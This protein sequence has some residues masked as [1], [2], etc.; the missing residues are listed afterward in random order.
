MA[1]RKIK[2]GDTGR[3]DFQGDVW[4]RDYKFVKSLGGG[5]WE[6]EILPVRPET[7]DEMLE[8]AATEEEKGYGGMF[9]NGDKL[10]A[11]EREWNE[12]QARTGERT[13]IRIVSAAEYAEYF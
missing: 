4:R 9:G 1:T 12:M 6:I 8:L 5:L 11:V 7:L 10:A 2:A 13:K 3:Y